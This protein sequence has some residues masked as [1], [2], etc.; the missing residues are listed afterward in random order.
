MHQFSIIIICLLFAISGTTSD[1]GM[2]SPIPIPKITNPEE[3]ELG[4]IL[5]HE[6]RL[7]KGDQLSCASCHSLSRFGGGDGQKVSIGINGRSGKINS[8]SI[9]NVSLN[10]RQFWNGR[11]AN[12]LEQIDDP[13]SN[14]LEM[15]SSWEQV[16]AKLTQDSFYRSYFKKI[17]ADGLTIKN[18]KQAIIQFEASLLTPDSRFDQYLRGNQN[19][20][21]KDEMEGYDLYRQY[22][23]ISCHQGVGMGGNMYQK[24]V[25]P[26][27]ENVSKQNLS[28]AD[29]GRFILTKNKNDRF[30]FKVPSLRNIAMT[31][32]YFHDASAQN[33][34]EVVSRKILYYTA[35]ILN[36]N[37]VE[38]I[39][40]FLETLTGKYNGKPV[41]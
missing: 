29:L 14:P 37:D 6:V 17:Y 24:F 36:T 21:S 2:I 33:L 31:A 34:S 11:A 20:L 16:I 3:I 32:P 8:P 41:K 4:R 38:K 23:C 28:E 40:L 22:G 9:F 25:E 10:F 30:V 39:V 1:Q 35:G 7:S 12:L 5:F 19:A 15:G 18:I 27:H 13:I 26:R